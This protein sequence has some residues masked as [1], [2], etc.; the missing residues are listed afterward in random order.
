V[1]ISESKE[2]LALLKEISSGKKKGNATLRRS[3]LTPAWGPGRSTCLSVWRAARRTL[4]VHAFGTANREQRAAIGGTYGGSEPF[5]IVKFFFY[6]FRE[7]KYL[8]FNRST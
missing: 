7:I 6:F 5:Q 8:K 2:L 3:V 1:I 4:H